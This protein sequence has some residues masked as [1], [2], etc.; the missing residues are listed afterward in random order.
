MI[1]SKLTSF[2]GHEVSRLSFR[3]HYLYMS[4]FL[5]ASDHGWDIALSDDFGIISFT[6]ENLTNHWLKGFKRL[7]GVVW[8]KTRLIP[9][10][11]KFC[12]CLKQRM[13]SELIPSIF[14]PAIMVGIIQ[15]L[16]NAMMFDRPG[17]IPSYKWPN[18]FSRHTIVIL[19][20][21]PVTNIMQ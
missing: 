18:Y 19:W 2:S 20:G 15:H 16:K 17:N 12:A 8:I 9:S 10:F 14:V 4:W 6:T 11:T 7:H 5:I 1:S 13:I 21:E 3:R